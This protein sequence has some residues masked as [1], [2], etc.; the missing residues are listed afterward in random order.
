MIKNLGGIIRKIL[1]SDEIISP[2]FFFALRDIRAF[3]PAHGLFRHG[4]SDMFLYFT[5]NNYVPS[6]EIINEYIEHVDM[7]Q[8]CQIFKF[9]V[10][11]YK[12][13]CLGIKIFKNTMNAVK[14]TS[15]EI[16]VIQF[17]LYSLKKIK[18]DDVSNSTNEA[19]VYIK[20]G[21]ILLG[22]HHLYKCI[23]HTFDTLEKIGAFSEFQNNGCELLDVGFQ[24]ILKQNDPVLTLRFL[25]TCFSIPV[26]DDRVFVKTLEYFLNLP[27][28]FHF[29]EACDTLISWN[30]GGRPNTYLNTVSDAL[31]KFC[32]NYDLSGTDV[33]ILDY[34]CRKIKGAL[35]SDPSA[36]YNEDASNR[37]TKNLVHVN[38]FCCCSVKKL[39]QIRY[40]IETNYKIIDHTIWEP[41]I[42]QSVKHSSTYIAEMM[43]LIGNYFDGDL[44]VLL[45]KICIRRSIDP[46]KQKEAIKYFKTL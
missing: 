41:M 28:H 30:T 9:V 37:V 22:E 45:D 21:I 5:K 27:K 38:I 40:L 46:K 2:Y 26:N 11:F 17:F 7:K 36:Q 32:I 4:A 20:E 43:K 35:N 12:D 3:S 34:M 10:E 29:F 44:I 42:G 19:L 31:I 33:L 16:E 1:Q 24:Y 6:L 25:K 13:S 15:S 8:I 14:K 23:V 39:D 18:L